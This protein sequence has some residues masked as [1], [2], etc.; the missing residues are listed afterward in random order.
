MPTHLPGPRK[1]T[2][3]AAATSRRAHLTRPQRLFS[4][5]VTSTIHSPAHFDTN[6]LRND[7]VADR[8]MLN[9][10]QGRENLAA[11]APRR[12]LHPRQRGS[13]RPSPPQRWGRGPRPTP[14]QT[15]RRPSERA[16]RQVVGPRRMRPRRSQAL[17]PPPPLAP[18]RRQRVHRRRQIF[19]SS[20]RAQSWPNPGQGPGRRRP[21][22]ACGG[23]VHGGE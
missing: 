22:C 18:F 9:D 21:A 11:L 12:A 20:G 7:G 3:R 2:A 6:P 23:K 10:R 15:V 17:R 14:R 4:G 16:P 8:V 5:R 13:G 1:K 19:S